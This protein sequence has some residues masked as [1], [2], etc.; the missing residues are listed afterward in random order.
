MKFQVD[1]Q[2]KYKLWDRTF[3]M[4]DLQ[5]NANSKINLKVVAE[6]SSFKSMLVCKGRMIK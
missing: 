4:M 3:C 2:I 6:K 5:I 1:K